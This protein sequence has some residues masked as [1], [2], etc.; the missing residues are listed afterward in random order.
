MSQENVDVV[1]AALDAYNTGDLDALMGLYAPACEVLPDVA[2]FPES[3]PP[4]I[5]E[6]VSLLDEG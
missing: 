4:E 3:A 6:L 2:V 1:L 5:A